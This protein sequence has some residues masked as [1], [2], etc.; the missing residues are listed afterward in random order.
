MTVGL[1]FPNTT[2][3]IFPAATPGLVAGV[4]IDT[5]STALAAL[6]QAA[7]ITHVID[8]AFYNVTTGVALDLNSSGT[9]TSANKVPIAA[10]ALNGQPLFNFNLNTS[11]LGMA[12]NFLK[13]ETSFTVAMLIWQ[14]AADQSATPN[15][16][17]WAYGGGGANSVY[18]VGNSA[19]TFISGSSPFGTFSWPTGPGILLTSYDAI[20]KTISHQDKFGTVLASATLTTDPVNGNPWAIGGQGGAFGFQGQIGQTVICNQALHLSAN[21]TTKAALLANMRAKYAI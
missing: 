17:L 7:G 16:I 4:P 13:T 20:T 18:Q 8:P 11:N 9:M 14:L 21:A 10:A 12:S 2:G 19:T 3:Y 6:A 15:K 1:G 5:N